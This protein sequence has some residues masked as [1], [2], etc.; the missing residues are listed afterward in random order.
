MT[1]SMLVEYLSSTGTLGD[2]E[3]KSAMIA[4]PKYYAQRMAAEGFKGVGM[5]RVKIEKAGKPN[6]VYIEIE[7]EVRVAG[8]KH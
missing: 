7:G 6:S 8:R 2:D 1:F 4:A 5:P 3:M